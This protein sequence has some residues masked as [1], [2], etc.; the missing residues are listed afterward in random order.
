MMT[1]MTM[2]TPTT[3]HPQLR[4]RT[5]D[6]GRP[7]GN[8]EYVDTPPPALKPGQFMIEEHGDG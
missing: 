3:L 6:G 4:T 8:I 2:M 7:L 5:A 1:M